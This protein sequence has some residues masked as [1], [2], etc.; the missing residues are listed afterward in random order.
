MVFDYVFG[1]AEP[2]LAKGSQDAALFGNRIG[3]DHVEGADTV[4]GDEQQHVTEIKDFA[5]LAAFEFL[6]AGD[7][8]LCDCVRHGACLRYGHCMSP[9]RNFK[10]NVL[11]V[12]F[13]SLSV[14][15]VVIL[16]VGAWKARSSARQS[17][18]ATEQ[19]NH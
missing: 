5:H 12:G 18:P 13:F 9:S 8:D 7:V 11:V 14:A 4:R 19:V 15:V 3:Q 2:E 10:E 17:T 16:V 1:L 6:D